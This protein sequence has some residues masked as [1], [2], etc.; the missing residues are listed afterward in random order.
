MKLFFASI[1]FFVSTFSHVYS[2]DVSYEFI[3]EFELINASLVE[4][5]LKITVKHGK[6]EK[7]TVFKLVPNPNCIETFP[8]QCYGVVVKLDLQSVFAD[9][10]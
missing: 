3:E 5:Q 9:D 7:P 2:S 4:N 10:N 6:T 8:Q 1:L